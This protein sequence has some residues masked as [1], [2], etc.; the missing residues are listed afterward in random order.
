MH[1]I[2]M[3]VRSSHGFY[4]VFIGIKYVVIRASGIMLYGS[5]SG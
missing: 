1:I 5:R 4:N 2:P 3:V